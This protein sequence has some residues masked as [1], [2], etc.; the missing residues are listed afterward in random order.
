MPIT[1]N[2]PTAVDTRKAAID[3]AKNKKDNPG[4]AGNILTAPTTARLDSIFGTYTARYNAL[5]DAKFALTSATEPKQ[6][7]FADAQLFVNHFIQVFNLGIKRGVYNAAERTFFG[8]AVGDDTV[9]PILAEDDL[10]EV[11]EK[12]ISGDIR[13]VTAGGAAMNNPTTSEMEVKFIAYKTL[14][15]AYSN[16]NDSFD[17]ADEALIKTFAEADGVIKK[18]WDEVE[19][20]Y[21]EETPESMRN[22]AREWGVVYVTTGKVK[23]ITILL[24]DVA[25]TPWVG[26]NVRLV[27]GGITHITDAEGKVTFDTTIEGE[28]HAIASGDGIETTDVIFNFDP[29]IA[30]TFTM[31]ANPA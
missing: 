15:T 12:I 29:D 17:T 8:I 3:K 27:D 30:Q 7:A 28:T 21:N 20:F 19:T 14:H 25:H 2:L 16:L 22:N 23:R 13:R 5:Q 9:P 31:L 18:V 11:A 4:A 24:E 6:L 10:I 1:R 26:K